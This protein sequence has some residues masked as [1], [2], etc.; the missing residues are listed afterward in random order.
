MSDDRAAAATTARILTQCLSTA[1]VLA[2]IG[3]VSVWTQQPLLVPSLASAAFLQILTPE[4]TSAQPWHIGMGQIAG[5]VAGLIAVYITATARVP[6][7]FDHQPLLYARVLAVAIAAA[8]AAGFQLAL[9]ATA[10]AGGTLAVFMALGT[11]TPDPAGIARALAGV[12]LITAI[13]EVARRAVI[14]VS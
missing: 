6:A 11:E 7:F 1:V 12:L 3:L 14:A 9:K 5:L 8:L 4:N 2:A 13:G 10:A